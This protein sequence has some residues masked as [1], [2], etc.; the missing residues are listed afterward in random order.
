MLCQKLIEKTLLAKFP[1]SAILGEEGL[2]GP[3]DADTRWVVDPID[4]TVNFTYGIP[5]AC[6]SI[7]WQERVGGEFVTIAG[8]VFD[9]F[10]DEM[11]T[12]VRGQPAR[13]NG[14]PIHVSGRAEL[15]ECIVSIGF[16][17]DSDSLRLNLPVFNQ[18]VRR[19]L[20]IRMM[21]RPR[22]RWCMSRA[23]VS[24]PTLN[25]GFIFGTSPPAG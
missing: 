10:C 14:R 3:P 20:K 13:L 5:H 18:L 2:A 17:K 12:A 15:R 7:A 4:G 9:P 22:S 19:V 8:V 21:A 23:D 11:W 6:V 16:A 1:R 25:P 24:T